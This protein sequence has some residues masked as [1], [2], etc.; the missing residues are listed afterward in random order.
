MDAQIAIIGGGVSG[1]TTGIALQLLG[2]RTTC[3]AEYLVDESA[4]AD[5]RFASLYPAAS[6]IPHSV[7]SDKIDRLFP[8]SDKIFDVLWQKNVP[9]IKKHRHF[10]V[11]E[12]EKEIPAYARGMQHFEPVTQNSTGNIPMR[13]KALRSQGW[14]FD[15]LV[16]EWP[17]YM[18][19]LYEWY[20]AS[21]GAV[22]RG[23]LE[24]DDIEGLEQD[25]VINCCGIWSPDLF[26][27][28]G[29]GRPYLVRGHL[30]HAKDAPIV[31]GEDGKIPSYNYTPLP[32][33]YSGPDGQPTD[34]YC[35]PRSNGWIIGG[36]RQPGVL[37]ENGQWKGREHTEHIEIDGIS[38][39]KG[40]YEV[41]RAVCGHF[42]GIDIGSFKDIDAKIGY[43]YVRSTNEEGLRLEESAEY[44]KKIFHNYGH[45]G[46]GITLSWGCALEV[47]TMLGKY[48]GEGNVPSMDDRVLARLQEE[49]LQHL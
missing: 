26:E 10:E 45:G 46:A 24:P 20:R 15:C 34:V 49:M 8:V 19:Q 40:L 37:D 23:R 25:L 41:N 28:P 32:E 16:T 29:S 7:E 42:L 47:V 12:F 18:H 11:F 33:I 4:P 14:M 39:P 2:C 36:S 5:P 27:D 9:S 43:R 21:G 35:Y 30:L 22:R 44:G 38:I 1:I 6:V 3:Y 48:T 17:Q 13:D 31:V